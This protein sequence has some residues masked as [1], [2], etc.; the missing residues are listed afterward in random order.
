LFCVAP[1]L[2]SFVPRFFGGLFE[3]IGLGVLRLLGKPSHP[4]IVAE[5]LFIV[6]DL[7]RSF[8]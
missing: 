4:E 8:R 6:L 5:K 1:F 3:T 2:V 7:M